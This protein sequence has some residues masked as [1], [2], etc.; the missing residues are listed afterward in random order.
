MIVAA[1]IIVGIWLLLD[2]G[3]VGLRMWMFSNVHDLM[4]SADDVERA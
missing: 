4:A 1:L 3:L 2:L